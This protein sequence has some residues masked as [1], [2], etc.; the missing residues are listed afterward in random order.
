MKGFDVRDDW[1]GNLSVREEH[2]LRGARNQGAGRNELRV[3]KD[4]IYID[5]LRI[6]VFQ[7]SGSE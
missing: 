3:G 6:R 5:R 4:R 2:D 7:R 1:S